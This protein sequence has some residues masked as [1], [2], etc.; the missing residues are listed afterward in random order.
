LSA[1]AASVAHVAL[2]RG[3]RILLSYR[4]PDEL[5][6]RVHPGCRVLAPLGKSNRR[7]TAYVAGVSNEADHPEIKDLADLLDEQPLFDDLRMALFQFVSSYYHASLGDVI[8]CGLP[9]GLNVADA[10]MASLTD[11]GRARAA[12]DPVLAS[13]LSGDRPVKSLKVANSK[14]LRLEKNGLL[15]L[16]YELERARVGVRYVSVVAPTGTEPNRPLRAGAGPARL[17]ALLQ[18]DGPQEVPSLSERIPN[19]TAAVRR[20][21]DLGAAEI[22]RIQVLRDPWR[23]DAPEDDT[24]PQLTPEQRAAVDAITAAVGE[25]RFEAF[26]LKGVTGSGKTE[27][28]LH[29]IEEVMAAG[30]GGIVL[31]PE[32]ALTPQLAGRFRARFGDQVAVLHSA[33]SDGERLDQW[34]LIRQG[35]RRCVVGARSALFAP[36]SQL[37]LVVVDEEHDGSFKQEETPRYHARDLALK[38]G[39]L[40]GCPVVLGSATPSLESIANVDRGRFTLLELPRRIGARTLPKVEIVDLRETAP[41]RPEAMLSQP[42]IDALGATVERGEQAIVFLNR[43]GYANCLLCRGCGHV[44]RCESC[45][46]SLTYHRSRRRLTCHYCG[47]VTGVPRDC[48]ECSGST[49]E[50]VGTG[51]EQVERVLGEVLPGARIARMDR[52]TTR[53]RQLQSLLRR[54]RNQEV[55]IL[56]GTQMVAKGHDFPKVTLVG[57]LLAEQMLKLPDF[58]SSERTFQLLTQV[59]GRA[60]RHE[61]P[62]KVLI[63]TFD[64][65]H[66]SLICAQNHDVDTFVATELAQRRLRSFPP[67]S[68]LILLKL[69][70]PNPGV[71]MDAAER[72]AYRLREI[73]GQAGLQVTLVG[74]QVAPLERIKGRTRYQVLLRS[75]D[76]RQLH[77]AVAAV[78]TTDTALLGGARMAVD[79][80]PVNLL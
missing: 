1:D 35:E 13:L 49:L 20:L 32:I 10:R 45:S 9:N 28:Y 16:R 51:T 57:V 19:H 2:P 71:V 53:G 39:Q 56:V 36:I 23:G 74:P 11:A 37:G 21:V 75:H 61:L 26:L 78:S 8:R 27:V 65:D 68:Y 63:Q 59:A 5:K 38:L 54:F 47:Y 76:R 58:R 62:G 43:R 17:L 24:V 52:D 3:P 41:V 40:V 79:V 69:D 6:G 80:D 18:D 4:I 73:I 60:G 14:L 50:L 66:H 67:F 42:L 46:V 31:V 25:P 44:P 70:A 55:D 48:S 12:L 22:E 30:K 29:A 34:N 15:S 64:P 33:L 77:R 7:M 72:V